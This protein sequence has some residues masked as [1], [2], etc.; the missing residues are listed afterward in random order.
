MQGKLG[1]LRGI[2]FVPQSFF[3]LCVRGQA[4]AP[5]EGHSFGHCL[6]WRMS[7][8]LCPCAS[9]VLVGRKEAAKARE[10]NVSRQRGGLGWRQDICHP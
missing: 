1:T 10:E 3:Q 7:S 2:G 8:S 5:R 6:R 4:Q 9:S